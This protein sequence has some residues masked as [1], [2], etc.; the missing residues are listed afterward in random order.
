M[1]GFC[2]GTIGW[3]SLIVANLLH[4][5]K[6]EFVSIA[7]QSSRWMHLVVIQVIIR[8]NPLTL[9]FLLYLILSFP[10]KSTAAEVHCA[11]LG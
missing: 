11:I 4:A 6:K 3:I 9:T 8:T 1:W 10:K 2:S 5:C 7:R